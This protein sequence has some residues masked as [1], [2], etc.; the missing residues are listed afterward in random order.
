MDSLKLQFKEWKN[1][2]YLPVVFESGSES[3]EDNMYMLMKRNM[4]LLAKKS[5]LSI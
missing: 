4:E 1:K 5:E 3:L 2:N